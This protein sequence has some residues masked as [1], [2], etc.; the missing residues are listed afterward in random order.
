MK[1][2]KITNKTKCTLVHPE[3]GQKISA[4]ILTRDKTKLTVRPQGTKIEIFMV[5]ADETIPY[6]G[7]HNGQYFTVHLD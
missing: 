5:R 7:A 3:T 2:P 1:P 4:D 6:R